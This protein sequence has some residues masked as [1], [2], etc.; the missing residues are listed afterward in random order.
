MLKRPAGCVPLD[1]SLASLLIG[2]RSS[3]IQCRFS[4]STICKVCTTFFPTAFSSSMFSFL[5]LV[6]L[7]CSLTVV[8]VCQ[9]TTR[10]YHL[11]PN[12][13]IPSY[14]SSLADLELNTHVLFAETPLQLFLQIAAEMRHH[15]DS[16][17]HK[18]E[19][20]KLILNSVNFTGVKLSEHRRHAGR[21]FESHAIGS[22][23]CGMRVGLHPVSV[24]ALIAHGLYTNRWDDGEWET[25]WSPCKLR[26]K[27]ADA[28][29]PDVEKRLWLFSVLTG[30]GPDAMIFKGV[31]DEMR[32]NFKLF[33]NPLDKEI[34]L[35]LLCD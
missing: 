9:T 3:R 23:S 8:V 34:I 2:R 28:M 35:M 5:A 20:L 15:V 1:S 30:H 4:F 18:P 16:L 31:A 19:N 12:I 11:N 22:G 17:Y 6:G 24:A 27:V 26:S 32:K 29:G 21:S 13:T 7:F 14:A 10:S 25:S 33:D